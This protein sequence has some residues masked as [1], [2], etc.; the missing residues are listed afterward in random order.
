MRLFEIHSAHNPRLAFFLWVFLVMFLFLG[1]GLAWRQLIQ[2]KQYAAK[3]KHQS[4]RRILQPGSRGDILDRNGKLLVGNRPRFSAVVHLNELRPEFREEYIKQVREMRDSGQSRNR[5]TL[6]RE[7]RALVIQRHLDQ[8][9]VLL[10]HAKKVDSRELER[11]FSAR[12]LLPFPLIKDLTLEEYG[13][14]TEQLSPQN[15]IQIYATSTRYYPY[16]SAAAHTL[17]YVVSTDMISPEGVPG[18]DLRTFSFKG[19]VGKS[20]LERYFDADLAGE[21]GGEVW[22]VDPSG[23]QYN[24]PIAQKIPVK[25][26][27]LVVSLDIDLQ[28]AAER[29]LGDKKGAIVALEVATGEVLVLASKPDYDLSHFS[30]YLSNA[31]VKD[32]NE[33]GAWLNRATQG[34]YPPGSTFKIITALAAL[35]RHIIHFQ[36][37]FNCPG[38]HRIGNVLFSCNARYGHGDADLAQAITDSCNVYFYKLG[39]ETGIKTISAEARRFRLDQP[40]GIELPFETKKMI[41]P[42]R[43]WKKKRGFGSWWPGDT[44]NTSIG[45]G[46]LLVTPLQMATFVTALARGERF[47]QPT[48][49]H[50]ARPTSPS[51]VTPSIEPLNLPGGQYAQLIAAMQNVVETGTGKLA[52]IDGLTIAGKTGTAQVRSRGKKLT[53]GW[54]ICFAPVENPQIALCVMLEGVDPEDGY[55][56][57]GT[58]API[59]KTIL[60]KYFAK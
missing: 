19:K 22:T 38:V 7:A 36:D 21:S 32:I 44:A 54:F 9:N 47:I 6:Q 40:T 51:T 12:L 57:G 5:Y 11:H 20:G 10:G 37:T 3:E 41:V 15:P 28:I 4:Q 27:D 50:R 53:L 48:L 49:K 13:L 26:K 46:F 33:R 29:A 35:Q 18:S 45:Q 59:A 34:L 1:A 58:A 55:T 56:G 43:E 39:L 2:G 52:R 60:E 30:P 23:F 14:L 25:G 24:E 17:G 31:V 8:I 16:G 42:D